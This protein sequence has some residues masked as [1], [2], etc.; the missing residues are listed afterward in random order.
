MAD[1]A[2]NPRSSAIARLWAACARIGRALWRR[3]VPPV[4][5]LRERIFAVEEPGGIAPVEPTLPVSLCD[6]TAENVGLVA[7]FRGDGIAR[8]LA[9]YL[10]AGQYGVYAVADGEVVG[11]V[12]AAVA[13]EKSVL[14]NSY[15]RVSPGQAAVH[16]GRVREDCRG[17]RLLPAMM[18]RVCTRAF[19]E[20]GVDRVLV[21]ADVTNEASIRAIERM[22]FRH[23]EDR[24]FLIVLGMCIRSWPLGPQRRRQED[25][26]TT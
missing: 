7:G 24:A 22:G 2:S 10:D 23:Q 18:V 26:T 15:L 16:F 4:H 25:D 13:R 12:W 20:A 17:N 9:A 5:I 8:V 6:V 11:H 1:D 3:C 14:V 21:N 19:R